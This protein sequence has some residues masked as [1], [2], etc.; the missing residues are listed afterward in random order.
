V[1]KRERTR[2]RLLEAALELFVERGYEATTVA[3]IAARAGVT[4]MTFFRHFPSK[5]SVLLD[6]PYDPLI[7]AA[8][9]QQPTE[10]AP[11]VRVARGIRSAWRSMPFP[12]TEDVRERVR[13]AAASPSLRAM[14]WRNS[15]ATEVAIAGALTAVDPAVARIAAAAAMAA[16]NT[17]LL[18]W[19]IQD[20]GDLAPVIEAALDVLEQG[21]V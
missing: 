21:R 1:T 11:L 20:G 9:A 19:S 2:T 3:Q 7:A 4:E 16:L 6:D 13:V 14:M 10:L 17:A 15:A 8:V 12:A 18:E 5:E